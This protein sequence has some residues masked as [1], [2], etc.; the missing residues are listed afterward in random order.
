MSIE[1]EKKSSADWKSRI[2]VALMAG[3]GAVCGLLLLAG[4]GVNFVRGCANESVLRIAVGANEATLWKCLAE[5][6]NMLGAFF[7]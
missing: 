7:R 4:E 3:G 5:T 6:P 1:S 2:G